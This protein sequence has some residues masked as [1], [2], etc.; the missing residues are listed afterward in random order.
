MQG[1]TVIQ[2]LRAGALA[3]AVLLVAGCEATMVQGFTEPGCYDHRGILEPGT[4]TR[5]ECQALGWQW[6]DQDWRTTTTPKR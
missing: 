6:Y 2:A 4:R 1:T 5:G 3:L